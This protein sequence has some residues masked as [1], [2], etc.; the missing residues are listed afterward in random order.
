MMESKWKKVENLSGMANSQRLAKTDSRNYLQ[1]ESHQLQLVK[2][3]LQE[4]ELTEEAQG[5]ESRANEVI[6]SNWYADGECPMPTKNMH[7]AAKENAIYKMSWKQHVCL[8]SHDSYEK[9]LERKDKYAVSGSAGVFLSSCGRSLRSEGSKRIKQQKNATLPPNTNAAGPIIQPSLATASK[10]RRPITPSSDEDS[11]SGLENSEVSAAIKAGPIT[12][13]LHPPVNG[14][15]FLATRGSSNSQAA[16]NEDADFLI[17]PPTSQIEPVHQF[18]NKLLYCSVQRHEQR[19][20]EQRSPFQKFVVRMTAAKNVEDT[21]RRLW[22]EVMSNELMRLYTWSGTSKPNSG[23]QK[24]LAVTGSR[25]MSAVIETVKYG[26]FEKTTIPKIEQ[27]SK[28]YIRKAVDRLKS[29][30]IAQQE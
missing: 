22:K 5:D 11:D 10:S 12:M 6:P 28:I 3:F 30:S 1:D 7:K 19:D 4:S 2:A 17:M 20:P 23:K 29:S 18:S 8:S 14:E 16:N 27:T 21:I 9:A 15:N 24:G 25:F 13:P 26:E